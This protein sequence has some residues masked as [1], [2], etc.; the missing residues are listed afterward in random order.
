MT[1]SIGEPTTPVRIPKSISN[2]TTS[3]L[4]PEMR[5]S[6]NSRL[7]ADGH[8][9]K[10]HDTLLHAL[11]ASHTDWPTLI[12]RR[13]LSLLRSGECT[14]FHE[15]LER[16]LK[17][18][19]A[20]TINTRSSSEVTRSNP[21][22]NGHDGIDKNTRSIDKNRAK[23]GVDSIVSTDKGHGLSVPLKV[24]EEGLKVT[25]ECLEIVCEVDS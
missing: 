24:V 17:D 11:H 10:I 4:D 9:S 6:V 22:R 2:Y 25:R 8:I 12:Q 21:T 13:A 5:S 14:T 19:H 7:L 23:S 20:D 3:T 15:V 18:I 1:S 16:V